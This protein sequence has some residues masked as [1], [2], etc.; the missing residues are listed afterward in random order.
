MHPI[1]AELYQQLKIETKGLKRLSL[2]A[3][4]RTST[5]LIMA[6]SRDKIP[7]EA[8]PALSTSFVQVF[9]DKSYVVLSGNN[10]IYEKVNGNNFRVSA[11]SFFQVNT[12]GADILVETVKKYLALTHKETLLDLYSGVGLFSLCL[13]NYVNKVV[14]VESFPV[15]VEDARFN[16]QALKRNNVLFFQKQV[17]SFLKEFKEKVDAVVLDPPFIR[18]L[19]KL[20]PERIVY[21]SCDPATL[22]RDARY[23][24][25]AD[26]Y[27]KEVQPLDLFPQT[28]HIESVAMFIRKTS[29]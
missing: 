28:F 13:A 6:E 16:I 1:L 14:A 5:K 18:E 27:L 21:V 9:P 4:I 2:R 20:N 29:S 24:T 12:N 7:I 10:H 3:G 11:Q 26:Y 22:A 15:S 23:F 19:K 17:L 8:P 25:E